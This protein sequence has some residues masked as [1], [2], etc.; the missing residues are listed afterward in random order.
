MNNS[1][2]ILILIVTILLLGN[3]VLAQPKI[4]FAIIG[5]FGSGDQN[6]AN[7][8]A[9]VNSWNVD[10]IVTVGDNF[11]EA[12]D[13][14]YADSW[15][16]LDADVGQYYHDLIKPYSGSYGSGSSDI[17]RFFPSLGN[18]DWYHLD[19]CMVYTDYFELTPYSSTSGNERYY[20]F[21]WGSVHFFILSTY[22]NGLTEYTFPRHNNYGEPDGVVEIS[23]QA[24]WLKTQLESANPADWKII[25]THHPPYSSSSEHGSEPAVQW[26][27]K[28]W[29]AD[30]IL[31][32]HDHTYERLNLD[33]LTYIVNGLGGG[34]IYPFGTPLAGSQ[35]RYNSD[36]G[37]MLCEVYDDSLNFQFISRTG[38]TIDNFTL[39]KSVSSV[40]KQDIESINDFR[41]EPNYPNPFNPVTIIRFIYLSHQM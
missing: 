24:L 13:G 28:D 31:S 12:N 38:S 37:A 10:F 14:N 23:K 21:T 26:P 18:H 1:I 2:K 17:N 9:L 35:V 41:L 7:V 11:Y 27:Y 22:G 15:N 25:I 32:G 16:A 6:E 34:D 4:K 39:K 33:N 19:S 29:G 5:D 3:L 30:L 40:D 20:D 8:A 36:Y